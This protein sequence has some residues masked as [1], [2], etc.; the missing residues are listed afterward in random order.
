[1]AKK[2][3]F[4]DL[5]KRLALRCK[6]GSERRAKHYLLKLYEMMLD[7]L[8]VNGQFK[9]PKFGVFKVTHV[10]EKQIISSDGNKKKYIYVPERYDISF[11]PSKYLKRSINEGGFKPITK[12]DS[13]E[14]E[15]KYRRQETLTNVTADLLQCAL[16]RQQKKGLE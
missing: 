12:I 8:K 6:D 13:S 15:H 1:M 4:D 7:E 2:T 9:I 5:L 10:E 3:A 16:E 14:N 11:T